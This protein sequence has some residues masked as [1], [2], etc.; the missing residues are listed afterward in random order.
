MSALAFLRVA[1]SS[2]SELLALLLYGPPA[3]LGA[4]SIQ[5]LTHLNSPSNAL[6]HDSALV[7]HRNFLAIA[8]YYSFGATALQFFGI[9]SA[10]LFA[11]AGGWL[12]ICLLVNDY[13][14]PRGPAS[15]DR[16]VH[17]FTYFM[18]Q[19][20]PMIVGTEV[21]HSFVYVVRILMEHQGILAFTDLFI[22]LSGRLGADAPIDH[23]IGTLMAVLT[24]LCT[25]TLLPLAHRF[26][27]RKLER[28]IG[29]MALLT[30]VSTVVFALPQWNSFGARQPKR[31]IS[32][33]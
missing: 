23:I 16:S 14:L 3:I 15:S 21:I 26:G 25:P 8:F 28:W 6:P 33:Q 7:E 30:V 2:G 31:V 27:L 19:I 11:I 1:Q 4:L 17:L 13:L 10:Y 29:V 9:G 20:S 18:A 32:L 24:F 5:W 12:T 22:P